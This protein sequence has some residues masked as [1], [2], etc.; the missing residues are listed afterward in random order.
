MAGCVSRIRSVDQSKV[1]QHEG[2][3]DL[4]PDRDD[5]GLDFL[6]CDT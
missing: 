3:D 5:H 1:G 2:Q 6:L 4:I